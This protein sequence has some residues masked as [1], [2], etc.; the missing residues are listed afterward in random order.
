MGWYLQDRAR[1]VEANSQF[2]KSLSY[3]RKAKDAQGIA[4]AYGNL[5]NSYLDIDEYQKSLNSQLL[6]LTANE[7]ILKGNP[8]GDDLLHARR[9]LTYA[10]SNI[11]AVYAEIGMYEKALE[12]EYRSLN[13]EIEA[14]SASH[15]L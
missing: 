11:G 7:N 12:Y 13:Y 6:S 14:K 10:L 2:Y 1:F 8:V 9:G 4:D 5:G 3:L 15:F